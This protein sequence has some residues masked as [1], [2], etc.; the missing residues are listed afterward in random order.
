LDAAHG[1]N[2]AFVTGRLR[3]GGHA[4]RDKQGG[5]EN[6]RGKDVSNAQHEFL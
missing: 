4:G 1:W 2:E 6:A 3:D 5:T